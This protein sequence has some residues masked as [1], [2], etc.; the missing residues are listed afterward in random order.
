MQNCGRNLRAYAEA[1]AKNH[2]PKSGH[3]F[4]SKLGVD[5]RP[6]RQGLRS[7]VSLPVEDYY[8]ALRTHRFVLSPDGDRPD[9]YR[10]YEAIGLGAVPITALSA[11][12]YAFFGRSVLFEEELAAYPAFRSGVAGEAHRLVAHLFEGVSGAAWLRGSDAG[13]LVYRPPNP[14]LIRVCYWVRWLITRA[15]RD[16]RPLRFSPLISHRCRHTRMSSNKTTT[17][18]TTEHGMLGAAEVDETL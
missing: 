11:E 16:D 2:T 18:T 12:R 5:H 8:E 15:T 9:C 17:T 14:A 7:G 13:S 10:N 1:L 4:F 3:V 6:H